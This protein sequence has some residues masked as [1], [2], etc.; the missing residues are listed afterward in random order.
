MILS[1]AILSNA[2]VLAPKGIKVG[3]IKTGTSIVTIDSIRQYSTNGIQFYKGATQLSPYIAHTYITDWATAV[4][5]YV[6]GTPWTAVG[7]STLTGTE[8]LTNKTLTS[9]KINENIVLIPTSTELNY[10]D[11]V[12][13]AIQTQLNAKANKADTITGS[14]V[15]VMKSDSSALITAPNYVTKKALQTAIAGVSGGSGSGTADSIRVLASA[16]ATGNVYIS[17]NHGR[18]WIKSNNYWKS[19]VWAA[20]SVDTTPSIA[21]N[22]A[23]ETFNATGYDLGATWS[24]T[25]G[26]GSV[27]DKDNTYITDPLGGASQILKVQKVSTNFDA[28]T[29]W[30]SS[31]PPAISYFQCYVYIAAEGLST[32]NK[33]LLCSVLDAAFH[34]PWQVRL[35]K[36]GTALNFQLSAYNNGSVTPILGAVVSLNTW[37]KVEVKWD[38]TNAVCEWRINGAVQSTFALTGTLYDNPKDFGLGDNE[39]SKTITAYYDNMKI[40]SLGYPTP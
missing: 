30:R 23:N 40:S 35:L 20:D 25:L 6:T 12:T 19:P 17:V 7:Y 28:K 33:V 18:L 14:T 27:V 8:T 29:R 38:L 4:S 39:T 10:V 24:E 26:S 15:V 9:P 1:M 32:T 2:Q 21:A 16:P 31:S 3:K 36:T 5:G 11:G 34:A 37:Y 22:L 13:S